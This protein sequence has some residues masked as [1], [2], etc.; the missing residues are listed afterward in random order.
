M[1]SMPHSRPLDCA[2][3]RRVSAAFLSQPG[4]PCAEVL[5][6]ERI[7]RIFAKHGNL[8][9][10]SA[11]YSTVV[12][13]WAF[14]GQVLRDKK[15]AVCQ[16]AVADVIVHQRMCGLPVPCCTDA[17]RDRSASPGP[18]NMCWPPG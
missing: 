2:G 17:N 5:S 11:I 13:L 18:A 12:V 9:G 7:Q 8:F 6:A 16:S 10:M 1:R 15:Q 4:L 3:F 14:L